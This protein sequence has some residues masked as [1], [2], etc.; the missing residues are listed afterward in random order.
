MRRVMYDVVYFRRC[1][2]AKT[3]KRLKEME[4]I[5]PTW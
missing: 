3:M 4:N 2:G 1:D 5:D